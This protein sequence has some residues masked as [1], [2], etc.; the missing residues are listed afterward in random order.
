MQ[1]F[2]LFFL[3]FQL[4][5]LK[6]NFYNKKKLKMNDSLIFILVSFLILNINF[7]NADYERYSKTT[8]I[9]NILNNQLNRLL[10]TTFAF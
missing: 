6:L 8:F 7:T 3:L 9:K 5:D 10:I 1:H 2:Y 4:F